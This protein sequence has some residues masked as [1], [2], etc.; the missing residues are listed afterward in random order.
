MTDSTV[1]SSFRTREDLR[2]LVDNGEYWLNNKGDLAILHVTVRRLRERWPQ[3]RIGVLT[4]APALLRAFEGEAVPVCYRRGGSWTTAGGLWG[5]TRFAGPRVVGT[6]SE[7]WWSASTPPRN[8][9]RRARDVVSAARGSSEW[10]TDV[11][12]RPDA[13]S[14]EVPVVRRDGG[15]LPDA[16]DDASLVIAMGGGYLTD[17]DGYQAHRTLALLERAVERGVP[18][19]LLGQ[20][21]GPMQ[22]PAL[23]A[24]ARRVLPR[25]DH[26]ALRE[27][28]KGPDLLRKI[29][30]S[31]SRV[32]ITGDDAVEL[33]YG[34]RRQQFGTD[35]G[36]CLRVAGY[37]PVH[38]RAQETVGRVVRATA[39]RT[40]AAL[41]PLIVS[42]HEHEDRRATMPLIAGHPSAL[43]PLHR[44]VGA[45]RLAAEVSRCRILVTGAYH[46]AVF[47]LSQGIPVVGLSASRYYDDKLGGL[48]DM[49]GLGFDLVH[50]D[51][52]DLSDR[53]DDAVRRLWHEAEVLRAPLRKRAVIQIDSGRRSFDSIAE[54]V[55]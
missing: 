6:A 29:G 8:V 3:A 4:N 5:I 2:I 52:P 54:L 14:F 53:L 26:I 21:I 9:V 11:R 18:T 12:N 44:F 34:A 35:L 51:S 55:R 20:G 10:G 17:V 50:L 28:H 38:P 1:D 25:V 22:D 30:V 40:G 47:A 7:L 48:G 39:D 49:F 31:D 36:V 43:R 19:A 37:S 27:R 45:E 13:E 46:V 41:V 32:V 33:G 24:H 16:V 23:L 42:E 15:L